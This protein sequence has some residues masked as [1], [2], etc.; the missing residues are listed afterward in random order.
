MEQKLIENE[1]ENEK[2]V[3]TSTARKG[4]THYWNID[5]ITHY[6]NIDKKTLFDINR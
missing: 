1:N 6:W 5:G 4:I 3:C 2:Y